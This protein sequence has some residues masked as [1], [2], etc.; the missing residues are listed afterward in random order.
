LNL[1][2]IIRPEEPIP[3][4]A[5]F[6]LNNKKSMKSLDQYLKNLPKNEKELKEEEDYRIR[7]L[8]PEEEKELETLENVDNPKI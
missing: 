1:V 6:M 4:I 8:I 5:N 7:S 3:F 2:E